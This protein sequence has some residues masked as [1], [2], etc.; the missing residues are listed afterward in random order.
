MVRLHVWLIERAQDVRYGCRALR[1]SPGFSAVAVCTLALGIGATT[2]I[3][4]LVDLL[5]F[6]DLPVRDPGNLVQFTY[7]YPGDPPLNI[8]GVEDYERYRDHNTVFSE[9]FGAASGSV[10]ARTARGGPETLGINCVTGN[11]FTALGVRSA[12]GRLLAEADNRLDAPAAAVVSWTYWN[13]R[14]H[15]A[16]DVIGASIVL[17]G[18]LPVTIVGV[19]DRSFS[20]LAVGYSPDV[21]VPMSACQRKRRGGMALMARLRDGVSIDRAQAEMRVL[22]RPRIEA[23][24]RRDPQWRKAVIDVLPARAGLS[25]PV[26]HQFARPLSVLMAL[27]GAVLMLVCVNVA[28]LLLAR[29]AARQ[30]EIATRV[31]LGATRFRIVRQLL[32]EALLL[33]CTGSLLGILGAHFCARA[34]L[35]VVVSGTRFPGGPPQMNVTIDARVLLF[36]ATVAVLATLICGLLPAL[37]AFPSSPAPILREGGIAGAPRA[38][39]LFANGLVVAQVALAVTLLSV[40]ALF[41]RHLW[42]LRGPDL[43]FDRTS[44]LLV[45]PD[46]ATAGSNP[47]RL[48]QRHGELLTRLEAIPGVRSATLAAT[49]PIAGGAA[50][51]FIAVEGFDEP[52]DARRRLML[53]VVAPRYFETLGTPIVSGRDFQFTDGD[54]RRVAIVNQAMARHYFAGRDPLGGRVRLEGDSRPYEIVGVVADAKYSDI[55]AAAPPTIYL[56]FFQHGGVAPEYALRTRVQPISIVEEVRRVVQE[57]LGPVRLAK[58]TTLAEQVDASIVPERLIATFA[59]YFGAIGLLL[60]GLGLFGL[61]AFTVARRTQEIGVRMA[62]GATGR[63]VVLM[64]VRAALA[65]AG[66]GVLIGVPI[67]LWSARLAAAMVENLSEGPLFPIAASAAGTLL[68]VLASAYVPARR[69][70]RVDPVAALRTE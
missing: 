41:A 21:W 4:S 61:L 24:A 48:E 63:V 2:A 45:R 51:R 57:V 9:M 40:S 23:F 19:A 69:A 38:R 20:G 46:A 42:N 16:P 37:A 47:T 50:S 65:L 52:P 33:A 64:V 18:D 12:T 30:R 70:S 36:T 22:D 15:R 58:V 55:R 39:R 32:T 56:H 10:D 25:T 5:I 27:L 35:H 59:S 11:Y 3:F 66:A 7:T 43:G 60:A 67:A 34:L 53:N 28:G 1:S 29:A 44:V 31:S 26:H 6:R 62:L 68:F 17:F 14:F 8:F 49:T 54:V 13:V